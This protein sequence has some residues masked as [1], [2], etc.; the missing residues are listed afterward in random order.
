MPAHG[1]GTAVAGCQKVV[2]LRSEA[3]KNPLPPE[4]SRV[5]GK[6]AKAPLLYSQVDR[7]VRKDLP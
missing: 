3:T 7:P 6:D 5:R 1:A 2:I 4:V